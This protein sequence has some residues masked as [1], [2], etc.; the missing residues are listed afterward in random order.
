MQF[1]S[2]VESAISRLAHT[3]LQ[4]FEFKTGQIFFASIQ[5]LFSNRTALVK[6]GPHTFVAKLEVPVE[7][8]KGYWFQTVSAGGDVQLKRLAGPDRTGSDTLFSQLQLPAGKEY[9]ALVS[10]LSSQ[11]LPFTKGMISDLGSWLKEAPDLQKGLEA[12]KA[13]L[14]NGLPLTEGIFHSLATADQAVPAATLLKTLQAQLQQEK[15]AAPLTKTIL[16]ALQSVL[17]PENQPLSA[18]GSG[19]AMQIKDLIR[20]LGLF[21]ESGIPDLQENW[22]QVAEKPLK[23]LLVEMLQKEAGPQKARETAEQLVLKMNGQQLVTALNTPVQHILID[24]PL[25]FPHFQTHAAIQWSGK[26]K[27]NGQLDSDYCKI[28]FYLDLQFSNE[29]LVEMNVQNRI[30][31]INV[32]NGSPQ[33]QEAACKIL[34]ALKANLQKLNYTLSA[35]H[36]RAPGD[37][38]PLLPA[39]LQQESSYKGVD[40][41]I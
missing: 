25:N 13:M 6:A 29:T 19:I 28:V 14:G 3:N 40:I 41:R 30:I 10:Y 11:N 38:L 26:Q 34:P 35:V 9:R 21:Y 4:T 32:S 12:A 16:S 31:S 37:G 23:A 1:G 17:E 36:F 20:K 5:K 2:V 22:D 18:T 33:F 24:L 27:N 15:P 7:S 39:A 8:G